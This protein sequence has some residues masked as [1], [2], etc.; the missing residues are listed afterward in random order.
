[1]SGRKFFKFGGTK[2]KIIT[3]GSSKI[4]KSKSHTKNVYEDKHGNK[5]YWHKGGNEYAP[6]SKIPKQIKYL[7]LSE[8]SYKLP[9]HG[10]FESNEDLFTSFKF[11]IGRGTNGNLYALDKVS[12]EVY[13]ITEENIKNVVKNPTNNSV[14]NRVLKNNSLQLQNKFVTPENI[15]MSG[16]RQRRPV[17]SDSQPSTSSGIRETRIDIEEPLIQH[18]RPPKTRK[19]NT[20]VT[21]SAIV[22]GFGGLSTLAIALFNSASSK[23]EL[24]TAK[25]TYKKKLLEFLLN[26]QNTKSNRAVAVTNIIYNYIYRYFETTDLTEQE[27]IRSDMQHYI[28]RALSG[29]TLKSEEKEL[30]R[31]YSQ[32]I[33]QTLSAYEDTVQKLITEGKYGFSC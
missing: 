23:S 12:K 8:D 17:H 19:L 28:N 6:V 16:L 20:K 24:E 11:K 15:E 25:A 2:K 30:L 9:N 33:D 4:R 27:T 3:G 18:P 13:Q 26:L 10:I 1:M 7:K 22:I 31:G 5:F 32:Y 21:S 29:N 14:L